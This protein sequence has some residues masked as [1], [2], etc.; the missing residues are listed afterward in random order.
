MQNLICR[1]SQAA[2]PTR[3]RRRRYAYKLRF[4]MY[5]HLHHSCVHHAH[6]H[7]DSFV[8]LH[9]ALSSIFV[10]AKQQWNAKQ[11]AYIYLWQLKSC[12]RRAESVWCDAPSTRQW[13][14]TARTPLQ[15]TKSPSSS[16]YMPQCAC[17]WSGIV[18]LN[19]TDY[20]AYSFNIVPY[21]AHPMGNGHLVSAIHSYTILGRTN[22][23][24]SVL[25]VS[26]LLLLL[27]V[28]MMPGPPGSHIPIVFAH[29]AGERYP[30]RI[31]VG[32][33]NWR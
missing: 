26:L 19:S 3:G 11:Y 7:R 20:C 21:T 4:E 25:F 32:R 13:R 18:C 27:M 22:G 15:H 16:I 31:N 6:A 30:K 17:E 33:M 24:C 8:R 14:R 5:L 10:R 1:Q 29:Y 28:I 12:N 9:R 23:F 2:L